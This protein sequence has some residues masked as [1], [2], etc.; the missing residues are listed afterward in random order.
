MSDRTIIVLFVERISVIQYTRGCHM[1]T[2]PIERVARVIDRYG[3]THRNFRSEMAIDEFK[4]WLTEQGIPIDKLL[5]REMVAVDRKEMLI[6]L[7]DALDHYSP[8]TSAQKQAQADC[9]AA[10]KLAQAD[11]RLTSDGITPEG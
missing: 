4:L 11:Y 5:S 9:E 7:E 3:T 8:L 6:V 10:R 2:D 1:T